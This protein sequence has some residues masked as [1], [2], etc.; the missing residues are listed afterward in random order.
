M[1]CFS[2]P[3]YTT[4]LFFIVTVAMNFDVL[5]LSLW[6]IEFMY[7]VLLPHT[8][9]ELKTSTFMATWIIKNTTI[10]RTGAEKQNHNQTYNTPLYRKKL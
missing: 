8:Q 7:N 2:V 4:V 10:I 6:F 9:H 3:V 1:F 5:I